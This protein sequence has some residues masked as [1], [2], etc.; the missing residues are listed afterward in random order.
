MSMCVV[1]LQPA[2]KV[3]AEFRRKIWRWHPLA[4]LIQGP[5]TSR[6]AMAQQATLALFARGSA[7]IGRRRHRSCWMVD[8]VQSL[9]LS[10]VPPAA[11]SSGKNKVT[12]GAIT[13][14]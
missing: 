10:H 13:Y 7:T 12:Q 8:D 14:N 11:S 5:A 1:G 3:G 9:V 2:D 6:M 4:S